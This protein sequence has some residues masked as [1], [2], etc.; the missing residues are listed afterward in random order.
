MSD[1]PQNAMTD[2]AILPSFIFLR[3]STS[4][5]S[6]ALLVTSLRVAV[7]LGEIMWERAGRFVNR[8]EDGDADGTTPHLHA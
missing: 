3:Q 1:A 7:K 8:K 6:S 2:V 4:R 5:I